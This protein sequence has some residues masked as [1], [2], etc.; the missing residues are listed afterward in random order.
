MTCFG[1]EHGSDSHCVLIW[2]GGDDALVIVEALEAQSSCARSLAEMT[3]CGSQSSSSHSREGMMKTSTCVLQVTDRERWCQTSTCELHETDREG[4]CGGVSPGSERREPRRRRDESLG[5]VPVLLVRRG[6]RG[7]CRNQATGSM[8]Y[9][10]VD[11]C[12][13]RGCQVRALV[14][15][16]FLQ[17]PKGLENSRWGF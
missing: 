9:G 10:V 3:H 4:L 5:T 14:I 1:G 12:Q 16:R 2:G 6:F 8:L 17:I 11:T 7:I 13:T 15:P